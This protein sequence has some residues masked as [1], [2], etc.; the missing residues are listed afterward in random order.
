M[1]IL[2]QI[3]MFEIVVAITSFLVIVTDVLTCNEYYRSSEQAF[4]TISVI[5]LVLGTFPMYFIVLKLTTRLCWQQ[6]PYWRLSWTDIL[7]HCTVYCCCCV[8]LLAF[9]PVVNIVLLVFDDRTEYRYSSIYT[10][11]TSHDHNK[12]IANNEVWQ[13]ARNRV[14]KHMNYDSYDS[15]DSY[16]NYYLAFLFQACF[17]SLPQSFLQIV[18]FIVISNKENNA[19]LS[20][21]LFISIFNVCLH[22]IMIIGQIS[23]AKYSID[24]K[25]IFCWICLILDYI[26]LLMIITWMFYIVPK[27][28]FCIC[29]NCA[30]MF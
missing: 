21:S 13:W 17:Q 25:T 16:D 8:I 2:H 28:C 14:S 3:R 27:F 26:S 15:F 18:A 20:I 23:F 11:N 4:F 1:C 9:A 30:R 6:Y 5:L 19:S 12:F 24:L 10:I 7:C 29:F 22:S